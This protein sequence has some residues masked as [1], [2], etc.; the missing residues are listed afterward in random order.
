MQ[1]TCTADNGRISDWFYDRGCFLIHDE[2]GKNYCLR[3]NYQKVENAPKYPIVIFGPK[4]GHAV[5]ETIAVRKPLFARAGVDVLLSMH[6]AGFTQHCSSSKVA[7]L[8]AR[9]RKNSLTRSKIICMFDGVAV[10][11]RCRVVPLNLSIKQLLRFLCCFAKQSGPHEFLMPNLQ[12][13]CPI[14]RL[15]S[16]ACGLSLSS[17]PAQFDFICAQVA[18][19]RRLKL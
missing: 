12:K 7:F 6:E 5:K 13:T 9:A 1:Q 18:E 19:S 2:Q 15:R 10:T 17:M 11:T 3:S 4:R 8:I 14:F 16:S